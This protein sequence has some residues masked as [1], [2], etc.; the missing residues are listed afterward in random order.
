MA[1]G[2]PFWAWRCTVRIC[3]ATLLVFVFCAAAFADQISLKNG[4]RLTGTIVKADS[5]ELVIETEAAG[6]V[7]V[8]WEAIDGIDSSKPLHF[9]LQNGRSVT[10]PVTTKHGQFEVSTRAGGIEYSKADIA[11]IRSQEE[12]RAYERSFDPPFSQN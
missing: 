9:E 5:K 6:T 12:Q 7:T 1:E 10:G 4:D 11:G 3:R 2:C 8:R